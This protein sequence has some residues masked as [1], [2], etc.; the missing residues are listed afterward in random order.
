[1]TLDELEYSVSRFF[2]NKK[3]LVLLNINDNIRNVKS[4]LL[5]IDNENRCYEAR[6]F[7]DINKYI[8]DFKQNFKLY[9]ERIR[10]TYYVFYVDFYNQYSDKINNIIPNNFGILLVDYDPKYNWGNITIKKEPEINKN[11]R[12]LTIEEIY[13][14][15]KLGAD[16]TWKLKNQ[17]INLN[18]NIKK[19]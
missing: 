5:S 9:D 8:E 12:K 17:I 2:G 7:T 18:K 3:N 1:M 11:Y 4:H 19:K 16:T 6:I 14:L 13:H 15:C 10:K